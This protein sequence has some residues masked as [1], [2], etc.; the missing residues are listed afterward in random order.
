MVLLFKEGSHETHVDRDLRAGHPL[1]VH[2]ANQ[3]YDGPAMSDRSPKIEPMQGSVNQTAEPRIGETVKRTLVVALLSTVAISCTSSETKEA[4]LT[5]PVANK[6]NVVDDYGGTKV[7]DPYRWM[8][9]LDSRKWP[10]GSRIQ[11]PHRAVL[12]GPAAARAL[13]PAV[14]PVVG[15]PARRH[16][17]RRGRRRVPSPY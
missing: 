14:D 3:L 13:Q 17:G 5:Y 1:K 15:L 9:A 7:A 4:G 2:D 10:T 12:E 11:R 6:D 8:E 16:A